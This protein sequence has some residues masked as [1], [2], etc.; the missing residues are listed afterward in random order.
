MPFFKRRSVPPGTP[1][2]ARATFTAG[3]ATDPDG[4][5]FQV[6]RNVALDRVMGHPDYP[7][8]VGATVL[9]EGLPP[10]VLQ[11]LED[12]LVAAC[13]RGRE[14]VLALVLSAPPRYHEFVF[15]S[16]APSAALLRCREV[17]DAFPEAQLQ[18]Y[19]ERDPRWALYRDL[20]R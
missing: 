13:E 8:R 20:V 4:K 15:Y 3:M 2:P 12:A 18:V 7:H 16:R 17:G 11:R 5:P 6:R 1:I 14:S 9:G 10:I 19:A